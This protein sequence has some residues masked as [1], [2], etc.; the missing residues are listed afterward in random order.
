M[1]PFDANGSFAPTVPDGGHALRRLAVKGAG[2]TILSGGGGLA[3]QV[4]A[5]VV[6]SRLLT[7]RD[8]GLVAMVMTF[9]L[10]LMNCGLN[11]ITEAI[12][13]REDI[14]HALASNFFWINLGVGSMLTLI[15]AAA[16]PL[17]ARF[18]GDALVAPITVG[19]AATIFLTST[20][21]LHLALL[22]RAML[23]SK[24]AAN[25]LIARAVSVLVSIAL[26]WAG[27]GYWALVV[28]ACATPLSPAIGAMAMCRWIPGPPRRAAGTGTML[29]FASHTYARFG[30][31]YF[32]RNTDY[33][34]VGWRFGAHQL[35]FYKKAYD[36]FALSAAQLVVSTSSVAVSALS[37]VKDDRVQYT[38]Y[39]LGAISV[40]A[41]IG[42]GL[43]GG[44]TLTGP[45]VIRILLGPRWGEAGRIFT[46]FAPGI[47]MMLVSGT[48]GWIHLSL[49]RADR[50]LRWS[51]FEWIATVL[52][53][54]AGLHWGAEGI[55]AAWCA[56][57]WLLTVPAMWYAGKPIGLG[58][59]TMFGVIWR[60]IVASL[61]AGPMTAL[62]FSGAHRL[63]Q[64]SSAGGAVLR[65]ACFLT[66]FTALYLG[67]VIVL[68]QGL[69]PL[70]RLTGLMREMRSPSSSR[71]GELAIPL[72][73]TSEGLQTP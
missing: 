34:I 14:T 53:F 40:M 7:P 8:F 36:L 67:A 4:V 55:A 61:F 44:L 57:F 18:Y 13:Q 24:V 29:K 3:I 12:I 6:L 27:W 21:V 62:I 58:V 28:G 15:F 22:K 65:T 71:R 42:M 47:G 23:F 19:M 48:Q 37:R 39:L 60:Y 20:S 56:S 17:L 31:N 69:S 33:L 35:G 5:T 66:V 45:D 49:G 26:G 30:V 11:G 2:M 52:L 43:A 64:A 63:W 25:D 38:R 41:V 16:A 9:S 72:N 59:G 54:I 68:Y 46:F 70:R 51:T 10:L 1:K 32:A 73:N 50:W